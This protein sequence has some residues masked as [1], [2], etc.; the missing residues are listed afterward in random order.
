MKVTFKLRH[1]RAGQRVYWSGRKPRT[2]HGAV[3]SIVVA[4]ATSVVNESAGGNGTF[5]DDW[6]RIT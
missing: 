1:Y 2:I 4:S 6:G 5:S 3:S